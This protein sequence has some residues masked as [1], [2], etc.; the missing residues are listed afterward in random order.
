EDRDQH[1]AAVDV[2]QA[3]DVD[4]EVACP[5]PRE[6]VGLDLPGRER[7]PEST[8]G[9]LHEVDTKRS[10]AGGAWCRHDGRCGDP[11]SHAQGDRARCSPDSVRSGCNRALAGPYRRDVE[12]H[13]ASMAPPN[14]SSAPATS[15]SWMW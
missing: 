3:R 13:L 9:D 12:L 2:V 7:H 8:R 10:I 1:L 11:S 14:H 15:S 4:F 5:G 6:R